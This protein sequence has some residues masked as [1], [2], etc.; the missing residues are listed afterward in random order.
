MTSAEH[1]KKDIISSDAAVTVKFVLI[2]LLIS[3]VTLLMGAAAHCLSASYESVIAEG[4]ERPILVVIDAGHGGEDGGCIGIDGTLEK[5]VNLDIA[6]RIKDIISSAGI[7]C[8]MTREEDT[9]LYGM[10]G[11]LSDYK[12]QKKTYDLKNRLRFAEEHSDAVFVSIHM[13]SF[14]QSSCRGVQAYFSPNDKDSEALA[15]S[16]KTSVRTYLQPENMREI[17]RAGSSIYILD[18]ITR[19]AVLIECGFLSNPDECVEL[20]KDGYRARLALSVA[21]AIMEH[22]IKNQEK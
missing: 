19:P 16:V 5:D 12:G 15:E 22:V 6:M 10:Y 1:N 14:P 2:S 7:R 8:V 17:K 11:D 20:G 18:R 21:S 13:N 9:A 4:E 3:L